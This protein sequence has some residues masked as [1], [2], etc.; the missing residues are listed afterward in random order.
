MRTITTTPTHL[1]L[2]MSRPF[3]NP[4]D[5]SPAPALR[6]VL[7]AVLATGLH[8]Q[9]AMLGDAEIRSYLGEPL[10]ARVTITATADEELDASCASLSRETHPF[11]LVRDARIELVETASEKR[12]VVRSFSAVNEPFIRLVLRYSCAGQGALAREYTLLLD[13]RPENQAPQ[14]ADATRA[15]PSASTP[16]RSPAVA[17]TTPRQSGQ[18]EAASRGPADTLANI[19]E[20]V[21]P[22][23]VKRKARYIDALRQLNPAL[24]ALG[25]GD[26]I[27]PG[28][29]LVLPDLK[30]LSSPARKVVPG[31]TARA[32]S[33]PA[34]A[35]SSPAPAT[36][37]ATPPP[38][39]R[40]KPTAPAAAGTTPRAATRP[41]PRP[42]QQG[43][44]RATAEF[45]LRLSGGDIDLSRSANVTDE[46]R[47]LLRE[48]QF[49]LDADDQLAQ[50]LALKNAVKQLENRL[51]LVQSQMGQPAVAAA[52]GAAGETA[53][54]QA[55]E[56]PATAVP[57]QTAPVQPQAA[58]EPAATAKP[59]AISVPPPVKAAGA[60]SLINTLTAVAGLIAVA[61][62]GVAGWS[63]W[64]GRQRQR[65]VEAPLDLSALQRRSD[66]DLATR[67]SQGEQGEGTPGSENFSD[68]AREGTDAGSSAS[69][70]SSASPS[71]PTTS[72]V[73][74]RA[75]AE[76]ALQQAQAE[77]D[78]LEL[79]LRATA[80]KARELENTPL[81]KLNDV[82]A[83]DPAQT[84]KL[85]QP[86]LS[87]Q[88]TSTP[89]LDD[90]LGLSLDLGNDSATTVDFPLDISDSD[91][92]G[93]LDNLSDSQALQAIGTGAKDEERVRRMQYMQDRFPE[94]QLN[95]ISLD[96]PDSVIDAARDYIG[97]LPGAEATASGQSASLRA[98][99]ARELLL[100]AHEERPQEM[101]YWLALFEVLRIEHQVDLYHDVASKFE[102]LFGHQPEWS[103]VKR[104]GRQ[105]SP[106]DA[107][108]GER[109][110]DTLQFAGSDSSDWLNAS[111][112]VTQRVAA[113]RLRQDLFGSTLS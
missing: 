62:L 47:V 14:I 3:F 95:T 4:A 45:Q 32:P 104:I 87:P 44:R 74:V 1:F 71:Q 57:T 50:F 12:F 6:W 10:H 111:R 77:A 91:P 28:V 92:L 37:P 105:L 72:S 33:A 49:L 40:S 59:A 83:F 106:A 34:E 67:S 36:R 51:N 88:A 20:G 35:A 98:A 80:R 26:P 15:A 46:Q 25:D 112:G 102:I 56:T 65:V 107:L 13:P 41:A 39:A 96:D 76:V 24:A 17:A 16:A 18:W 38:A 108:Y 54:A 61:V 2:N 48:K 89:A 101:R 103:E 113:T 84:I 69:R 90:D 7:M 66:A 94:L 31:T 19:A 55:A 97:Q 42:T 100:F 73:D 8:A 23:S 109:A 78:E 79:A 68:W 86:P 27:P 110:G 21:F 99:R 5:C 22:K 29:L 52:P 60:A 30:A 82:P 85:D 64:R 81:P 43:S 63:W 11:S 93:G 58:V 75:A 70:H 9:A 53:T